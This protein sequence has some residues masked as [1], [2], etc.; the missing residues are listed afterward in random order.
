MP[1]L[2]TLRLLVAAPLF[3]APA[4]AQGTGDAPAACIGV[5]KLQRGQ[6]IASLMAQASSALA[7]AM[8]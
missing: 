7:A 5:G 3:T 6:D 8:R 1:G 2:Q 4:A